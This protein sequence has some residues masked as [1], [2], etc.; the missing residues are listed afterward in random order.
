[1]LEFRA[2]DY[3]ATHVNAQYSYARG[4][5]CTTPLWPDLVVNEPADGR[6]YEYIPLI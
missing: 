2:S 1:M 4:S 6:V 5:A 3:L